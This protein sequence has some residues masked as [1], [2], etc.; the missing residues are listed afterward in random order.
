M[1][2][3]EFL[4]P[5]KNIRKNIYGARRMFIILLTYECCWEY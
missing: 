2:N 4:K 3:D 1:N 5:Y